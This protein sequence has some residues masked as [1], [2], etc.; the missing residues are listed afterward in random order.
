MLQQMGGPNAMAGNGN[1]T[2]PSNPPVDA[3]PEQTIGSE[4]PL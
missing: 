4:L 2:V 3:P 1:G